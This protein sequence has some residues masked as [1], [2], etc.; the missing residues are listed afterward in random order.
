MF[1]NLP[2][3]PSD[4]HICPCCGTEFGNDDVEFSHEQLR[5]MW[6]AAG[7]HWFF[8]RAP[9]HWNPWIQ[10]FEAGHFEMTPRIEIN[11]LRPEGTT[12]RVNFG[13]PF[14]LVVHG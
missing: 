4:Y 6:I 3:P 8:G 5:E 7:A 1:R 2:Y 14:L 9:D 11:Y 10:L 13:Q 12:Q